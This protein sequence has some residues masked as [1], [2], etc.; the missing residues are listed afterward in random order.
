MSLGRWRRHLSLFAA[1]F[2]FATVPF[3]AISA[4]RSTFAILGRDPGIYQ[5]VAWGITHGERAYVD[6]REINGPLVYFIHLAILPIARGDEHVFRIVDTLMLAAASAFVGA[7][8]PGLGG[9]QHLVVRTRER[10]VWALATAVLLVAQYQI[11]SWWNTA[12]RESFYVLF[13]LVATG[14]QLR[15]HH[16]LAPASRMTRAL[17]FVA[18][19]SSAM[20]WFGKPTMVLFTLLQ[21][22]SLM[23]DGYGL[24]TRRVRF[25]WFALGGLAAVLGMTA[26][27]F[28]IGDPIRGL[29]IILSDVPRTYYFIWSR[30]YVEL[31]FMWGNGPKLNYAIPTLILSVA[32]VLARIVPKRTLAPVAILVGGLLTFFLQQ[33]GF[34][35]HLHS[36]L[37]GTHVVW[38][39]LLACLVR[40]QRKRWWIG[41]AGATFVAAMSI[42]YATSSDAWRTWRE[43]AMAAGARETDKYFEPY[44]SFDYFPADMR[45]AATFVREHTDPESRVQMYGM[46]PYFLF[47][48]ERRSASSFIYSFELNVDAAIEGGSGAKPS[49]ADVDWLRALARTHEDQLIAQ[50]EQRPPSAFV[51]IDRMPFT[52]PEDAVVDF[53][54]H[55]PRA[56]AW[57][58]DRYAP[59]ARFHHVHVWLAR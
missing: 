55:C 5:Y 12:Q 20:T 57:M 39:A 1:L 28:A 26:A 29:R 38:L 49:P 48:A 41:A 15:A 40:S 18:G 24:P 13:L 33:K 16:R 6:F 7:S 27:T 52:F 22:G 14:A 3:V 2:I 31:Y 45:H 4:W 32:L 44:T 58:T 9:R 42:F 37:V 54:Q 59:A 23:L 21:L 35:Y 11:L 17:L 46:D 10:A 53:E 34:P 36:A 30:R 56:Y 50:L 43:R 8:L 19:L 47:F 51:L 25:V